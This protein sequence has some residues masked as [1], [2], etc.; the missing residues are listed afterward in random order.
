MKLR[1]FIVGFASFLII[2]A[3]LYIVGYLF[4]IPMLTF[5]HQYLENANGFSFSIYSIIPLIIGLVGSYIAEKIYVY[6]QRRKTS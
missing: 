2:T 1:R 6:K 4:T 5:H 3:L